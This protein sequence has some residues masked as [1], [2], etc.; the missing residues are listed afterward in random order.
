LEIKKPFKIVEKIKILKLY[1]PPPPPP[2]P[3][4]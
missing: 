3:Q 1:H 4:N 2:N